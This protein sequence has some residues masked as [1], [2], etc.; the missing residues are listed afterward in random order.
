VNAFG[1]S[2]SHEGKNGHSAPFSWSG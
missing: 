1:L 2:F